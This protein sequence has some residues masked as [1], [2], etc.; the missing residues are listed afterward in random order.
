MAEGPKPAMRSRTVHGGAGD[1][2]EQSLK[3]EGIRHRKL[4]HSNGGYTRLRS[5]NAAP[6]AARPA[7][8]R[9]VRKCG[10]QT[11]NISLL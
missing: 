2:G 5:T 1:C 7:L 9:R 4:S 6:E 11:S 10:P 8:D 3:D